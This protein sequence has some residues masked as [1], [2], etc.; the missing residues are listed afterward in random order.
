MHFNLHI[1]CSALRVSLLVR[2]L[3]ARASD[4]RVMY[5][6]MKSHQGN[7]QLLCQSLCQ[8]KILLNDFFSCRARHRH[9]YRFSAPSMSHT[10]NRLV[11]RYRIMRVSPRATSL[12]TRAHMEQREQ[13]SL[14]EKVFI[15]FNQR[16][17]VN[18][19]ASPPFRA[20]ALKT[21]CSTTGL[22][23]H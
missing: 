7:P 8:Q 19:R 15:P 14:P 6:R 9:S 3:W 12:C 18:R 5:D 4:S 22:I 11:P 23:R 16:L 2:A 20:L 17:L 13:N 1:L 10:I 21:N